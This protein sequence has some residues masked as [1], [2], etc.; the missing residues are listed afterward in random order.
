MLALSNRT[1][2]D[3]HFRGGRM[4]SR[5]A[6]SDGA[7]SNARHGYLFALSATAVALS[8]TA[9]L[10]SLFGRF[11]YLPLLLGAVIIG[12][13][14]GGLGPG[15]AAAGGGT[16]AV[17]LL[18]GTLNS[19]VREPGL[20][21]QFGICVGVAAVAS[22]IRQLRVRSATARG[23][24]VLWELGERVK[25]LTLLH[26]ATHLLQEDKDRETLLRELVALLPTGWQTPET[27][28]ARITV[29][30]LVVTTPMFRVT[31]WI[32]RAEFPIHTGQS[33]VLEIACLSPPVGADAAFLPEESSLMSSLAGLL[34]SYFERTRRIEERLELT[35][36]QASRTEAEVAN[37]MKDVF[38]ATVSHELRRPLTAILGWTRLLREGGTTET[39]RGLDVIER[40]ANIQLRLIEEL[41]D[42]SRAATGQLGVRLSLVS[43]ST[44]LLSVADAASPTAS[45][46]NVEISTI[47]PG[48]DAPVRGDGIRLQQ[49]FG[50][51]VGNAI[52]L[53]PSGGRVTI[54]LE[55]SDRQVRIEIAD[56]GIG[57]DPASL[58][59]IFEPFWQADPS[60]DE[61]RKGLGLGL[62]IARRLVEL[63]GGTIGVDSAGLGQGTRM[64]VRLPIAPETMRS[65]GRPTSCDQEGATDF[66]TTSIISH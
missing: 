7:A 36:A 40:N 9:P 28:E 49:V 17:G 13:S 31:P 5:S 15:I 34:A 12:A 32:Q 38:L 39:A 41:L 56:T 52:R 16:V 26:R 55:R 11:P 23:N 30:G 64:I 59:R 60:N 42:L 24:R 37:S 21:A 22:S 53:T 8:A 18:G 65:D 4:V 61:S 54:T 29:G 50:N 2:L 58:P 3:N 35:R 33:G 20:L 27:T 44:I 51:L 47:L 1:I 19:I 25:E 45:D 46:R 62:A 63:H 10:Q 6:A 43:L 14:T 57:I 48:E 66:K